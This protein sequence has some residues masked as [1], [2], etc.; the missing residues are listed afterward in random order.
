MYQ[1]IEHKQA[2]NWWI[3]AVLKKRLR[4]ISL[5]KKKTLDTLIRHIGLGLIYLSQ[6]RRDLRWIRRM[7]ITSG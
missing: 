1:E 6:L 7:E 2:F 5:V 4:I 3:K